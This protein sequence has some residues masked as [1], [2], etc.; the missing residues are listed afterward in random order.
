[1]MNINSEKGTI[2]FVCFPCSRRG[3]YPQPILMTG[4]TQQ[5]EAFQRARDAG[6]RLIRGIW[7]CPACV[8]KEATM[9]EA[10]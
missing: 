10:P 3:V 9:K 2:N 8:Q 6:W 7:H 4:E 5:Q 1:M